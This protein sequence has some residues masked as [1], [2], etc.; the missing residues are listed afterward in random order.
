MY[1]DDGKEKA[2]KNILKGDFEKRSEKIEENV[3]KNKL[4]KTIREKKRKLGE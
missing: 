4:G 1:V 2:W 3:G